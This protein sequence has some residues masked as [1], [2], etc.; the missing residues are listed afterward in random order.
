MNDEGEDKSGQLFV[1]SISWCIEGDAITYRLE[2]MDMEYDGFIRY[3]YLAAYSCEAG[4]VPA[5]F[6]V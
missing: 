4:M 5:A 3:M 1:V 6:G 2:S